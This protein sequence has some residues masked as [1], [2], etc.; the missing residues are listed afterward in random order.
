MRNYVSGALGPIP[1]S[2]R[3]LVADALREYEKILGVGG[4]KS[5]Y[6]IGV[7][8]KDSLNVS[9]WKRMQEPFNPMDLKDLPEGITKFNKPTI[10]SAEASLVPEGFVGSPAPSYFFNRLISRERGKGG[11]TKVLREMLDEM[12]KLNTPLVN[13]VSPYGDMSMEQIVN[14]YKKEGFTRMGEEFGD[15]L[16]I[17][18]PGSRKK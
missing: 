17:Y 3:I 6:S 4:K 2:N 12:D 11:G 18:H 13:Q 15:K 16:L 5:V 8:Q 7:G 14:F 10:S 1:K 9:N